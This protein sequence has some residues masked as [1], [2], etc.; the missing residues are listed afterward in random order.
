MTDALDRARAGDRAAFDEVVAPYRGRLRLHCYRML[1]SY[2]DADDVLQDSLLAAWR[3]LPGFEGR[4]S[5]KTWLYRIATNRC[6]D[7]RRP[8][9]R[10]PASGPRGAPPPTHRGEVTWLQPLPDHLIELSD[11]EPGPEARIAE[12]EAVSLAFVRLLQLLPPRQR[13]V[14]LLRDVLGYRASEA[15]ELLDA[16]VD[17]VNG[18]L[19]RA[20]A[21]MDEEPPPARVPDEAEHALLERFV[22]LFTAGDVADLVSLFTEDVWVRMPPSPGEYQGRDAARGFCAAVEGHRRRVGRMVPTR[23]NGQ[24]A[25]G[26]Y[27]PDGEGALRLAGMLVFDVREVAIAAITHFDAPTGRLVGLPARLDR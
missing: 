2:Q 24:P 22:R 1:G 6:L 5:V 13:A 17:S 4:S 7:L 26:E 19:K 9:A 8:T 27:V 25:L 21:R 15:A 20:R 18:A 23:C 16:S 12:R 10:R 14:L 3:A 11:P